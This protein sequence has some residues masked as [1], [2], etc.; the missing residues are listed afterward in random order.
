MKV[1]D[2]YRRHNLRVHEIPVGVKAPIAVGWPDANIPHDVVESRLGQRFNK[3][4]WL[5]DDCHVVIDIDMHNPTEN[6]IESLARLEANTGVVLADHC[7]AIVYSPS[8]GRHYYFTKPADVTFGKVFKSKYPGIDFISGKGK[9]VIA[10]NSAHDKY[11][12]EYRLEGNELRELPAAVI[13]HLVELSEKKSSYQLPAEDRSGDEFNRSP[14]GLAFIISLLQSSGYVI[15]HMHD[16]Y[17]FDRPN[18][19]SDS[20]CSGHVGKK[21]KQGNYQLT[22]FSLS[23]PYFPSGEALTIF[24][25]YTLFAHNGN[26]QAAAMALYGMGFAVI[27]DLP[28]NEFMANYSVESVLNSP[29]EDDEDFCETMIPQE[30]LLRDV[31]EFY[32]TLTRRPS[33]II[34]LA[35]AVAFC[36]AIFGRRVRSYTDLRTHDYTVIVAPTNCGKESVIS[37]VQKLIY[38]ADPNTNFLIPPN[39]QSGNGLLAAMAQSPACMWMCDEFGTFLEGALDKRQATKHTREIVD[40]LLQMYG[41]A[42]AT[43]QGAAHAAGTKNK[44]EQPS[45]SL[46]GI[47]TGSTL[48]ENIDRRQIESG[49]FGRCSFW[50]VQTRPNLKKTRISKPPEALLEVIRG[51]ISFEP[52]FPGTPSPELPELKFSKDAEDRWDEHEDAIDLRMAEESELRAAVWGRT[53]ARSMK[54]ALVHRCAR[55]EAFA[56]AINWDFVYVE[57]RDVDWGVCISN[58]LA[59]TSCDYA[60]NRVGDFSGGKSSMIL[61]KILQTAKGEWVSRSAILRTSRDLTAGDIGAAAKRLGDL[62]ETRE[63]KRS[64]GRP[65]V[66]YRWRGE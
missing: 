9:Q 35:T 40:H 19:S 22:C 41:R 13:G 54:L 56:G 66:Q 6:G 31:Y 18:K 36:E 65:E 25:A 39:V 7:G 5:L 62:I 64:R 17:E 37:T 38:G 34:G 47:T 8:G 30:G 46:L 28:L 60:T 51:W 52:G 44:I 14:R 61:E 53:A 10:A 63:Q 48:F 24:H 11:P 29:P 1:H 33:S 58:W 27:E 59:R 43:Y 23:D 21:S 20:K 57:K 42:N 12:G 3:Y 32:L 2:F 50:P 16:Y 45:L 15:R 26:H 4:G 49:L 55:L